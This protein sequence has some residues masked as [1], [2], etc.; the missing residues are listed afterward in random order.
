[1][2]VFGNLWL[3]Y[4]MTDSPVPEWLQSCFR[5]TFSNILL[6]FFAFIY[7]SLTKKDGPIVDGE[8]DGDE[9]IVENGSQHHP[10][11]Q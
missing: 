11:G 1:M 7:V 2:I 6:S 5:W 3:V 9:T 4:F 8:D 10:E